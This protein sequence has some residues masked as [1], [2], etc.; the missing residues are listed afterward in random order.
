MNKYI[1]NFKLRE[2]ARLLHDKK[3][4]M[5]DLDGTLTKSKTAIDKE[6]S[7]LICKLLEKKIVAVTGGGN[8]SQFKNQFLHYLN[9]AKT[10]FKNLFILPVSGGSLYKHRNNKWQQIYK[11][12]LTNKEKANILNSFKE[13]FRDIHYTSP[14]KTYGKVIEDRESQITFSALGQQAPLGKKKE[15]NTKTDIRPQLKTALEK[16][17][18]DFEIRLGGLTSIDITKKGIDKAYGITQIMQMMSASEKEII[19]IGDALYEGGNDYVVKRVGI[20]TI[21][22]E[23]P[24]ETKAI[25]NFFLLH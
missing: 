6:T 13:S 24:E 3:I 17:L 7:S 19:Y 12:A 21:E 5:F 2:Y 16:Y 23:G 20:T 14:K 8:Y 22:V 9:C 15:W 25:V 10:R 11:H 18:P 4:I 1:K